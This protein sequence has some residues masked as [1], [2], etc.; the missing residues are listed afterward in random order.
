M[1]SAMINDLHSLPRSIAD[2]IAGAV[3]MP[4]LWESRRKN[5]RKAT[6]RQRVLFLL[7]QNTRLTYQAIGN[8]TSRHY[9]TVTYSEMQAVKRIRAAHSELVEIA[10]LEALINA[11]LCNKL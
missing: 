8:A 1:D 7:C 2:G 4:D 3:G 10:K 5:T 9:S 11:Y 6:M